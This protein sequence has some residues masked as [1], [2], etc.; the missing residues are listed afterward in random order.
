MERNGKANNWI[1]PYDP[2]VNTITSQGLGYLCYEFLS[3]RD[4]T[5][6]PPVLVYDV[7]KENGF[8]RPGWQDGRNHTG[9]R[10]PRIVNFGFYRFLVVSEQLPPTARAR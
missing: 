10:A 9:T 4:R 1:R 3:V 6:R 5:R 8:P 7:R 2:M